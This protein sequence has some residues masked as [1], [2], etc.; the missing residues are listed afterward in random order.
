MDGP[1][2]DGSLGGF[3][4]ELDELDA[5]TEREVTLGRPTARLPRQGPI[6]AVLGAIAQSV[7]RGR[8]RQDELHAAV[9]EVGLPARLY[10]VLRAHL[11]GLNVAIVDDDEPAEDSESADGG[12][13]QDG[14]TTF[15]GQAGRHRIL[16]AKEERRLA[17]VINEGALAQQWLDT[18]RVPPE[19][20][21]DLTRKVLPPIGPRM[22]SPD[23][24]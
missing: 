19:A 2:A 6:A 24:T 11:D 16:T 15:L 22:S 21:S 7:A 23:A 3:Q 12:F 1:P 20:V 10:G 17:A 13:I 8:I 4:K 5:Y 18:G 14:L 9:T